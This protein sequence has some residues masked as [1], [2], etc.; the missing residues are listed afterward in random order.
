MTTTH[1]LP[2]EYT[3]PDELTRPL[4]TEERGL[5]RDEVRLMVSK[6]LTDSVFHTTFTHIDRYLRAGDLLVFNNSATLPAALEITLP[7]GQEGRLHLSTRLDN[8]RWLAE[9]RRVVGGAP[10]RFFLAQSGD[11]I[12]LPGGGSAQLIGPHYPGAVSEDHIHLWEVALQLPLPLPSYLQEYGRPIR[13]DDRTFP[14]DHYQT[15]FA[16][17]AGSAEMPSAG[18]AFT[19]PLITRLLAKG[20]QFAPITLHTGV[21]SLEVEERPYAEYFEVSATTAALVNLAQREGRRIIAVGTTAVRA[22]ES[23]VNDQ[24]LVEPQR[25]WT[26]LYLTPERGMRVVTGLLTGLHEPRASHLQMLEALAGRP[27]LEV[28]YGEAVT[29]GYYWHEFGDLHLIL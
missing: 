5:A 29:E 27:H 2:F 15:V 28:T 8:D 21:S 22:L 1:A 17:R 26:D 11:E 16:T 24:G 3:L 7:T 4:P 9:L 23:A 6:L 19:H 25:G 18:R 10:K 20:V 12:R 14:L 13:Y